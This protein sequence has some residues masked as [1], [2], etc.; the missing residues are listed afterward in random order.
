MQY[1]LHSLACMHSPIGVSRHLLYNI[2][3]STSSTLD[4]EGR[5][6]GSNLR[7][8]FT[9]SCAGKSTALLKLASNRK[10]SAMVT[11][12]QVQSRSP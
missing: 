4:A 5:L 2:E 8:L 9:M 11:L 1:T 6:E 10:A 7:Q 3:L 12:L